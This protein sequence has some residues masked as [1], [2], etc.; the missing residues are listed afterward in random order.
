MSTFDEAKD[1]WK[2]LEN[3]IDRF[4]DSNDP[5]TL[6]CPG[7]PP[8]KYWAAA[9]ERAIAHRLAYYLEAELRQIGKINDSSVL[10]VDCEYNRHSGAPKALRAEEKLKGIVDDARRKWKDAGEDG[11]YVFSVA[12]DIVVHQRNTD[13]QN[14]LVVEMKKRS[15]RE[16]KAYDAHK[17]ELF[18]TPKKNGYGYGYYLGAWVIAE[19]DCEPEDRCLKIEE[20]WQNSNVEE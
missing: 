3:A 12:P 7:K 5:Q 17:L 19:D 4:N 16:P 10:S 2:C 8:E 13:D 9:G 15:N 6:L 1:V 11:Y 20:V 14:I 18:T